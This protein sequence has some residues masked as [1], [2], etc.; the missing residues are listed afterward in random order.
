MRFGAVG[1]SLQHNGKVLRRGSQE[2]TILFDRRKNREYA[3]IMTRRC[4]CAH[5][6]LSCPLHALARWVGDLSP[7]AAPFAKW[8]PR[9]VNDLIRRRLATAGMD[10]ASSYSSKGLRRGHA[11]D[12]VKRKSPLVTI[13]NAGDWR[14]SAFASYLDMQEVEIEAVNDQESSDSSCDS[15]D[16]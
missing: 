4:S 14:S 16:D 8:K 12:L 3:T 1:D 6:L 9:V 15:E 10:K 11:Q 2:W 5:G 13:L 7:P